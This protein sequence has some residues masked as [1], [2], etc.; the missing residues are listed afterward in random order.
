MSNR[1]RIYLSLSP[2]TIAKLEAHA[3][4]QGTYISRIVDEAV[5]AMPEP[6]K[7][8]SK[9]LKKLQTEAAGKSIR[10]MLGGGGKKQ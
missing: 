8:F 4:E 6:G 5:R 10:E 3:E 2:I 7:K 1:Q 9:D